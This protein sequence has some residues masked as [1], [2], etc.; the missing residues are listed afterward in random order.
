MTNETSIAPLNP[1]IEHPA[2]FRERPERDYVQYEF[3]FANGRGASVVRGQ[4]T[5]GYGEGLWELAVVSPEGR[6]DY[7]TPITCDVEGYLSED[8]VRTLL[9]RIAELR[10]VQS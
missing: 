4:G 8:D 9:R 6:L 7:S 10:A 3:K 5:Y 1:F 2:T